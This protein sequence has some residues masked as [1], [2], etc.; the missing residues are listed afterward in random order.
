MHGLSCL[1]T[2]PSLLIVAIMLL[3]GVPTA[4]AMYIR[5]D[6]SVTLYDTLAAQAA[7]QAAG[8]LG[9]TGAAGS[10]C[11][12]A[13]VG[14]NEFLTAAHCLFNTSGVAVQNP[15]DLTVGFGANF[16]LT[17]LGANNVASFSIDPNYVACNGCARFD[18]AVI[19]LANAVNNIT[20]ARIFTGNAFGLTGSVIGYGQQGTGLGVSPIIGANNRLGANNTIDGM[21]ESALTPINAQ[22]KLVADNGSSQSSGSDPNPTLATDFDVPGGNL[23]SFGSAVPLPLEGSPCFGDSGGPLFAAVDGQ[24]LLVGDVS[25]G[26][27]PFGAQCE[28]GNAALYA[29]LADPANVDYLQSL[30]SGIEFVAEPADLVILPGVQALFLVTFARGRGRIWSKRGAVARVDGP[31]NAATCSGVQ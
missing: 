7:F 2:L 28:Y 1:Y 23:S 3:T 25:Q 29:T 27:N 9:N 10:F 18:V 20:P 4:S 19:E 17:R 6:V 12:G 24:Q 31:S 16:P 26:T 22:A 30:N 21:S 11:S 14:P 15:A 5:D 13:L 8:Y